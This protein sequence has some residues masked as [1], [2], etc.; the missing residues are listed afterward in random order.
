MSKKGENI[1][2]RKDNRWEARYR[3][4]STLEGKP[5]YRYCY[6]KTYREV[7][8]KLNRERGTSTVNAPSF[9]GRRK[10]SHYCDEWLQMSRDRVKES[11]YVKYC[12]LLRLYVNPYLG[13][14]ALSDL[15]PV[16]VEN[17]SHQLLNEENLSPKSVRDILILLHSILGYVARRD[18]ASVVRFEMPYP[19]ENR[20]EMRILTREEQNAFV[21]CLL[22]SDDE[23]KFGVLL[24]LFT[25]LRIGEICA[26]R[27]GDVSLSERSLRIRSTLQ[28]LTVVDEEDALISR[29]K[30]VIT[31]PKS[32]NSAREIPMT[33]F[34]YG[35]CRRYYK[36]DRNAFVLT[37]TCRYMEPRTLQYRFRKYMK[38]CELHDVHFHTLRHTFATR[39]VEVEFEIKSLS[40]ILGHANP[41]ITLARYVHTSMRLKRENME[42]LNGIDW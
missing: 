17:F 30:I 12:S 6:G 25:G 33:D 39:C 41:N 37:G 42:K 7:K 31:D 9:A 35:I 8:E 13:G 14:Y 19:K 15:T 34:V 38:E 3:C 1:Y 40:E 10:F 27:W 5:K 20:K 2:R 4:G 32:N 18:P 22:E 26:L 28:R 24:A 29:T 23:C 36:S 11:T 21:R 16:A